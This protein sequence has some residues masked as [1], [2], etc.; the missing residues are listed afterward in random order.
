MDPGEWIILEVWPDGVVARRVGP[1]GIQYLARER[2]GERLA[3]T[4]PDVV[5]ARAAIQ[6]RAR[7]A[8]VVTFSTETTET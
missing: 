1:R 5:A 3:R 8:L 6:R 4:W 7:G 2:R